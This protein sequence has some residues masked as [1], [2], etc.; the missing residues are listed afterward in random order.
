MTASADDTFDFF[1]PPPSAGAPASDAPAAPFNPVTRVG[2]GPT[3]PL[4]SALPN[5]RRSRWVKSDTTF[6]P[7]GRIVAS[8][9]MLV[10]FLFL[11]A[12]GLLTFDPFVLIG[13]GIWGFLM[14]KGFRQVWQPVHH[15][16]RR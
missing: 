3:N 14:V 11:L 9:G 15:L 10:P 16:H 8:V 2:Q 6:G 5:A 13:A 7:V 1:S 4:P 12:A